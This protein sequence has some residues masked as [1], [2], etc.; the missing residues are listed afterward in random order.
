MTT[1]NPSSAWVWDKFK[2][3]SESNDAVHGRMLGMIARVEEQNGQLQLQVN[4][5]ERKLNNFIA[6]ERMF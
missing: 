4:D 3:Y 2:L 6:Q 5:L 1:P